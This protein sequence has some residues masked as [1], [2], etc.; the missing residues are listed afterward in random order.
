MSENKIII[1]PAFNEGRTISSVISNVKKYSD[2]DVLVVDDGST[3]D[4]LVKIE[5]AGVEYLIKHKKNRGY[6][7]SL[8][9]GFNFAFKKGYQKIVTM[10]CDAQHEPGRV[11]EFFLNIGEFDIVSGSRYLNSVPQFSGAPMQRIHINNIITEKINKITGYELT[12]AFCGFKG[13]NAEKLEKLKLDIS[14]YGMPL[15]L[16]IQASNKV[17]TVKEVPVSIIYHSRACFPGKLASPEE[18]LKYYNQII[19]NETAKV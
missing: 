10:D 12:D 19:E 3:D 11:E 1:L 7:R 8:I 9:H 2:A 16:W 4:T 14:G 5:N 6:G 13:Y 15:Q 18:R 17:L